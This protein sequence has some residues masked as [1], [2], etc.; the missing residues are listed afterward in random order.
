MTEL[1]KYDTMQ[2]V[3][4]Q[5]D[6]LR[7]Q[8]DL[9]RCKT[10]RQP[11]TQPPELPRG[12][13]QSSANKNRSRNVGI[14]LFILVH[15]WTILLIGS[16]KQKVTGLPDPICVHDESAK[17]DLSRLKLEQNYTQHQRPVCFFS[18]CLA[19]QIRLLKTV[20]HPFTLRACVGYKWTVGSSQHESQQLGSKRNLRTNSCTYLISSHVHKFLSLCFLI[21]YFLPR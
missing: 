20:E 19:L 5:K 3:K 17:S 21:S 18:H 6:N 8:S 12:M 10:G 16:D 11:S 7:L 13:S 4:R 2:V 14:A 15:F 9:V 1:E